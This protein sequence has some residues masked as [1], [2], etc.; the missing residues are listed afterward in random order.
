[1]WSLIC[2]GQK[3]AAA[4]WAIAHAK[5]VDTGGQG[6]A[7]VF[8][9]QTWEA[10]KQGARLGV[11]GAIL[12]KGTEK[13]MVVSFEQ[14]VNDQKNFCSNLLFLLHDITGHQVWFNCESGKRVALADMFGRKGASEGHTQNCTLL[15]SLEGW[16]GG[17]F[18]AFGVGALASKVQKEPGSWLATSQQ[19]VHGWSVSDP[20]KGVQR[21]S[22]MSRGA[23][24]RR[25]SR[26]R[27]LWP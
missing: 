18:G 15:C 14:G 12:G 10:P 13:E 26:Q 22:K 3:N 2:C 4:G 23:S 24:A 8:L 17:V 19:H 27:S 6:L 25:T 11:A 20:V 1:M 21:L 7:T 16:E 9:G 5:A